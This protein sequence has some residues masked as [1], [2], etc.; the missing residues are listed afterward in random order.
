VA[1]HKIESRLFLKL[2]STSN[3]LL[4][5]IRYILLVKCKKQ[6]KGKRL[7]TKRYSLACE[8]RHNTQLDHRQKVFRVEK[9]IKAQEPDSLAHSGSRFVA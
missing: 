9:S 1:F 3:K 5:R 2:K 4:R 6:Q 8:E 7:Y